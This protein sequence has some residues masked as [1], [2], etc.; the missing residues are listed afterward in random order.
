MEQQILL[1]HIMSRPRSMCFNLMTSVYSRR[2]CFSHIELC[3]YVRRTTH[4]NTVKFCVF[5]H[6]PPPRH[7]SSVICHAFTL[8]IYR[9]HTYLSLCTSSRIDTVVGVIRNAV[10][11]Y[12]MQIT[13]SK[14]LFETTTYACC[15]V[16][17][18]E[19]HRRTARNTIF[20]EGYL[21]PCINGKSH[22]MN[23]LAS[24]PCAWIRFKSSLA[25]RRIVIATSSSKNGS[26]A[27]S[28]GKLGAARQQGK[29]KWDI[30]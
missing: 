1:S 11:H 29:W 10:T 20:K 2:I 14:K 21:L 4:L 15:A 18:N 5:N 13:S 19:W 8:L 30:V 9:T 17:A 26:V 12:Y 3:C 6:P 27:Y 25:C 24:E 7:S 28:K 22:G 16:N 23:V